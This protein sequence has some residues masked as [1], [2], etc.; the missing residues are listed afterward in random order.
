MA[1]VVLETGI[2]PDDPDEWVL[3]VVIDPEGEDGERALVAI[4]DLCQP[5][6][7]T[8]QCHVPRTDAF[9]VPRLE[10]GE[11]IVDVVASAAV[12]KDLRVAGEFPVYGEDSVLLLQVVG[13]TGHDVLP[14]VTHVFTTPIEALTD[15]E[16]ERPFVLGS[17]Y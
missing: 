17:H 3:A 13:E 11:L 8:W 9:A 4:G 5:D 7:E 2:N 1:E 15:N 6:E 10:D 12:L 14:A 16:D